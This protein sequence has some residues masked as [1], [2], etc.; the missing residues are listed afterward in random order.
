MHAAP[1]FVAEPEP[2]YPAQV[3]AERR[4]H[5]Q[6]VIV[7]VDQDGRVKALDGMLGESPF[8]ASVRAALAGAHAR[9]A[10]VDGQPRVS[11]SLARFA[12]EF[13]GVRN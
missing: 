6:L 10:V 3:L 5:E 4:Q 12:W 9:P 7:V 11:W 1:D 8:D 2:R 13:V